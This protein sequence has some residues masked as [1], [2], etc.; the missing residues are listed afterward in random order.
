MST[1]KANFIFISLTAIIALSLVLTSCEQEALIPIEPTFTEKTSPTKSSETTSNDEQLYIVMFK[2]DATRKNN[3][4]QQLKSI[5]SREDMSKT[6]DRMRWCEY[7]INRKT[8]E[9]FGKQ[10]THREY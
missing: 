3:R 2:T 9:G 4:E 5:T 7:E 8:S 6:T 10:S 1:L